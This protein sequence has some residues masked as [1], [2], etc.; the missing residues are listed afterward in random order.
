MLTRYSP[1]ETINALLLRHFSGGEVPEL[2]RIPREFGSGRV[3][4]RLYIRLI[5]DRRSVTDVTLNL[6]KTL[7]RFRNGPCFKGGSEY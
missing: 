4:Q 2:R 1:Q 6:W 5:S 7:N 3:G